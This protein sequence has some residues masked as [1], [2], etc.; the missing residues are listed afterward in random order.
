MLVIGRIVDRESRLE[1]G[2]CVVLLEEAEDVKTLDEDEGA[3]MLKGHECVV[4]LDGDK[5]SAVPDEDEDFATPDEGKCFVTLEANESAMLLDASDGT[6]LLD[7]DVS[8]V[9][10]EVDGYHALLEDA[11]SLVCEVFA[12]LVV[13]DE[14]A[15]TV[16]AD[17]GQFF[18]T[19]QP[20]IGS[21]FFGFQWADKSGKGLCGWVL[22]LYSSGLLISSAVIS[23]CIH[24]NLRCPIL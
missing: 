18:P 21:H 10:V 2:E 13:E 15:L 11:A 23:G 7:H 17:D 16:D 6:L 9:L 3:L 5:D 19:S 20:D 8:R 22:F 1:E 24:R 12:S 14:E 4:M